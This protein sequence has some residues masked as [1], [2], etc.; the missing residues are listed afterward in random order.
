MVDRLGGALAKIGGWIARTVPPL[1]RD[2][3][4]LT[5][6]GSISYGAWLIH[7]SAGYITGGSLVLAGVI[8]TAR[9]REP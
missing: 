8:L 4:G 2:A 6:V 5:A 3:V 9:R 1:F 7:P